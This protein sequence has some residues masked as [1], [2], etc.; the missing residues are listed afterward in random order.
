[1]GLLSA[2]SEYEYVMIIDDDVELPNNM[3]FDLERFDDDPNLMCLVFPITGTD[4]EGDQ[5]TLFIQ[6]QDLE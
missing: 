2:S 5:P 6:W 1:M 4:E 3:I